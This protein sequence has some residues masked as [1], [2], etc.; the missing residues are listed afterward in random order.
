MGLSDTLK[1]ALGQAK[2]K[3]TE[4]AEK[5]NSTID[6]GLD[7]VGE[8]ADKATK[9]K[10]SDKI[11]TGRDKAKEALDKVG[12]EHPVVEGE[13]V[14]GDTVDGATVDRETVEKQDP[15]AS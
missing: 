13:T 4:F 1:G 10:Y 8:M 14:G 2:E 3:A 7:K 11:H 12:Q 15:P 9:G 5:H 6:S